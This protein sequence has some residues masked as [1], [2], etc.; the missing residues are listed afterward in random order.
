[1]IKSERQPED[2]LFT[3][4]GFCP[5]CDKEVT[6]SSKYSWL[7]D[8]FKCPNCGSIPRER[9][10]MTVIESYYPNWMDLCIHESSPANRGASN[11]LK[12]KAKGY[13]ASHF[14]SNQAK[15]VQ[16][17]GYR[18]EDLEEMTFEDES[19]D[20]VITQDVMEH[21]Y[22]P[23]MAFSE[24]A[25]ILRVGGAHIFTVPLV[26]RHKK[27]EVWATKSIDGSPIFLQTPEFHG[28]PIDP[29]GSPVTM[30]WGFDIVDFIRRESGL[31]TSIE[32]LD[33]LSRGIRA[34]YI[35]VLVSRKN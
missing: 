1:M 4:Y 17:N 13:V 16:I 3:T 34:Q 31:T 8:H 20:L 28:N 7:R 15:G 14:F 23:A 12:Q 5:C 22:N 35:E 29:T 33:D 27:S 25:R 6:F 26:N 10:L 11:K 9:A 18:N 30:H 2:F 19:F 21:I 24:I 32:H